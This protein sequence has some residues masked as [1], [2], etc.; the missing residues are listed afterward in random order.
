MNGFRFKKTIFVCYRLNG[1]PLEPRAEYEP[2][3]D[4]PKKK[5]PFKERSK[6][7]GP[8]KFTRH[9]VALPGSDRR[10]PEHNGVQGM[11]TRSAGAK[12]A[13]RLSCDFCLEKQATRFPEA[14]T[15]SAVSTEIG[16]SSIEPI[17]TKVFCEILWWKVNFPKSTRTY[18]FFI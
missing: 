4:R 12:L 15:V 18:P 1:V 17:L 2:L 11:P 5:N 9:F 14:D 13:K 10:A 8:R 16:T 6:G 3:R 7:C